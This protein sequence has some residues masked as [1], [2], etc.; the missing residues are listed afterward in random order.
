MEQLDDYIYTAREIADMLGL[1]Y[2]HIL[3]QCYKGELRSIHED[4]HR[5]ISMQSVK[6]YYRTPLPKGYMWYR[7]A[8]DKYYI[9]WRTVYRYIEKGLVTYIKGR[10]NGNKERVYINVESL[11]RVLQQRFGYVAHSKE[12]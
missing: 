6:E 12:L 5:Y 2:R 9:D 8:A 7:D 10:Y 1:N 11:E 4:G 3:I